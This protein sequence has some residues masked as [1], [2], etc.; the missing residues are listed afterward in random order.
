[1]VIPFQSLAAVT[2]TN[3]NVNKNFKSVNTWLFINNYTVIV[4]LNFV[5]TTDVLLHRI[6]TRFLN[7][8]T[9][10]FRDRPNASISNQLICFFLTS[11]FQVPWITWPSLKV[12]QPFSDTCV[13]MTCFPIQSSF[14]LSIFLSSH[15]SKWFNTSWYTPLSPNMPVAD[16][17][18]RSKY[19]LIGAHEQHGIWNYLIA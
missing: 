17:Q 6:R 14:F 16:L 18:W 15:H 10:F 9:N 11:N 1:M 2:W 19:K 12:P 3:S 8:S 5:W 4:A 7:T 13:V